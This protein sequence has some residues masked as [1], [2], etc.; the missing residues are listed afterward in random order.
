M[1]QLLSDN[2]EWASLTMRTK[3]EESRELKRW[4]SCA[5]KAFMVRG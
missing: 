3:E 5:R 2:K 4:P 1:S